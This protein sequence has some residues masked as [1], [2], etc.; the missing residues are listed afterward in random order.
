VKGESTL[1]LN[2][3][4]KQAVVAEISAQLANA[5]GVVLAE[6]RSLRVGEMT[7]LR[8]KARNSGVYLRVLKNTLA[9]RAVADTPFKGLAE[10]M[11]GPLAYGISSDPVAAA[12]V[13]QEFA[14]GNEKFVIRA[15]A[16]PNVV[17]SPKEVADLAKMPGRQELLANFMATMQAPVTKL[18]RTLN[19]V[20]GRLVRT[21]AAVCNQ[22]EKAAA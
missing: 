6:Y 3:E 7:E 18:V 19:E 12:K 22:R 17:M 16:M 11:I 20:P 10:K 21:M 14:K 4:Q 9:R 5:Q 13:L 1:G 2:L 15:G 8:K